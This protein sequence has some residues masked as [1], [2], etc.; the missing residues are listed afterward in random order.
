HLSK[1]PD[2]SALHRVGGAATW[3]EVP[4]SVWFF[5]VKQQEDDSTEPPSY[6]MVN[7]KLNIVADERKK[8]LG[9]TFAGVDVEIKGVLQNMGTIRWGEESS[10]T[11]EQQYGH[12]REKPGPE[13]R[14]LDDAMSW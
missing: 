10:V 9:Y 6:V 3:I 7:G 11:L 2:V 1:N 14:K 8:S 13:P 4:R 12:K 5:D